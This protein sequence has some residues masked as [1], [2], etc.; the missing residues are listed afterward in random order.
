MNKRDVRGMT[1]FEVLIVTVIVGIL[2][3]LS[4]ERY[5]DLK[6]LVVH[7]AMQANIASVRSSMYVSFASQKKMPSVSELAN[8]ISGGEAENGGIKVD[9]N[10]ESYLVHTYK[11]ANCQNATD[12]KTDVVKCVK[13]ISLIT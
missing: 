7:T 4:I 13:G 1:F 8:R 9:I 5:A 12:A 2:F 10:G 3:A 11:D 6:Q